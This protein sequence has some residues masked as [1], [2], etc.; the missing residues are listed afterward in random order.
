M[1]PDTRNLHASACVVYPSTH[2][3]RWCSSDLN[4]HQS[5]QIPAPDPCIRSHQ[6]S[7]QISA[8]PEQIPP[9]PDPTRSHQ[10]PPDPS[11]SHQIPPEPTRSTRTSLAV[12]DP[13][14]HCLR[15]IP[16]DPISSLGSHPTSLGS[17][18]PLPAAPALNM[19]LSPLWQPPLCPVRPGS[20]LDSTVA[21]SARAR[22][23]VRVGVRV[24][25]TSGD[26]SADRCRL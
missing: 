9:S 19:L 18:I 16:P 10:I 2:T 5:H 24:A 14:F 22:V 1:I 7:P 25:V 21:H 17:Q 11:R 4:P 12:S 8:L 26:E 15:R 3:V 20:G 6:G 23:R 13:R